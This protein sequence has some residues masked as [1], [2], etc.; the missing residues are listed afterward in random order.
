MFSLGP[1]RWWH[2]S[3]NASCFLGP[4][5]FKGALKVVS[6]VSFHWSRLLGLVSLVSFPW[7][8]FLGLA[9]SPSAHPFDA[10]DELFQMLL[11]MLLYLD[12]AMMHR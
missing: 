5:Q 12:F 9:Q 1:F 7:S 2:A 8:R 10:T 11:T 6:L 3:Y 4:A